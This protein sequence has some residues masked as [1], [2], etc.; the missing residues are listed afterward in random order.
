MF[1]LEQSIAEWR[2]QMLAAGI[3]TPV[4]LEEL[5]IHLHEE[6][7]RQM[8]SG[9][10]EQ[11]AFETSVQQIGQ[12][13]TLKTEFAKAGGIFS[14]RLKQ[15]FL[16]LAG[17]PNYQL[18]TNMNT[19]NQNSNIEPRWATYLK[20][21]VFIM[22]AIFIWIGFLVLVMPKLKEVCA[23]SHTLLPWVVLMALNLSDLFRQYFIAG[24][25]VALTALAFLEWRVS[26][27][28][29]YRKMI[30]GVLAVVLNFCVLI[31]LAALC[32]CAVLA[33]SNLIG[34]SHASGH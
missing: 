32:V 34:T 5:E 27:W 17:I 26:W 15:F 7:E 29:R 33:A 20:A 14:E 31:L 21:A 24:C 25:V 1:N 8:K 11:A 30:F 18:A 9:L 2:R 10:D 13:G 12:A 22:P 6:I 3:E 16:T 23:L 28:P 19:S 4:P